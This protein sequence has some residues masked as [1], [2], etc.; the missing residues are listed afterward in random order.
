MNVIDDPPKVEN[1]LG[2]DII[3]FFDFLF[4]DILQIYDLSWMK[5]V[6]LSSCQ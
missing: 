4:F 1:M 6:I 3:I 5:N 2:N